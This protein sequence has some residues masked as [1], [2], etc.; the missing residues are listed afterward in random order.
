MCKT[1]SGKVSSKGTQLGPGPLHVPTTSDLIWPFIEN[2][3]GL[4][5]PKYPGYVLPGEEIGERE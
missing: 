2:Q 1:L 4:F 3:R 5:H